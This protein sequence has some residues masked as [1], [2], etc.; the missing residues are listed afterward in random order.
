MTRLSPL[1]LSTFPRHTL[2]PTNSVVTD[3]RTEFI[4]THLLT[5]GTITAL[6]RPDEREIADYITAG[7]SHPN[8]PPSNPV[9]LAANSTPP[10]SAAGY[11]AAA[12]WGP[13]DEATTTITITAACP[14][15]SDQAP[16]LVPSG[17]SYDTNTTSTSTYS[18][19]LPP[20]PVSSIQP[21][22]S[23]PADPITLDEQGGESTW[24][25]L[26]QKTFPRWLDDSNGKPYEEAPWGD[27]TT[28]NSD[29]TVKEDVPTTNVTR[30]YEW[31]VTRTQLSPDG[32]LRDMIV[33]NNAFPGPAIEA[34]W[35]DWIEVTVHNAITGPEEGTAMHWHGMLQ[36]G[37]QWEDGTPG[38]SQCPIAPGE[39][40]TYRFQ[41]EVYGTSFWHAH[42]SAQY[43]AGVSG[44]MII[45]G[46]VQE[47]APYDV[48][49]GPVMLSDWNHIP[50]FSMVNN[51]VGTDLSKFPPAS[52]DGLI[53]GR[54]RFDCAKPSYSNNT[55]WLGT[56]LDSNMTWT[57]VDGSPRAKFRFQ[58]GKTHRL[59]LVNG[60]A[61]GKLRS[62]CASNLML[63]LTLT[64]GVQKFSI[65]G[66]TMTVI[67]TDYVPVVPYT[68][69]VITL[70][71]G[72]RTD[73]LVTASQPPMSSW[74]MRSQLPG[75]A[76]CGGLGT[77]SGP[78]GT[79]PQVLAEVYYD[80]VPPGTT[81]TSTSTITSDI[82]CENAPLTS[83][84]P[85]YAL[86]PS[87]KPFKIDLTLSLTLNETGNFNFLINDQT[88]HANFNDPMLFSA[89]EGTT[90][91]PE[92][93]EYNVYD[94]GS[95]PSI[96]LNVTNATPFV[97]PFH[98][99]G[100]TF[101]VLDVG[102]AAPPSSGPPPGVVVAGPPPTPPITVWSG[103]V[104]NPSSP[105]RRDVQII[106]AGG[107]MALQF[108]ADNPGVWPFHCHAAWHLSGGLAVNLITRASEIAGSMPEGGVEGLRAR[109][110]AKWDAW[111]AAGGVADQ[112][113]SGS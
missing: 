88:Y 50:Y 18:N 49:L 7:L 77:P 96:L 16:T 21:T 57:C 53:N 97:H 89:A 109:S 71:V 64:A 70:G 95:S 46:P 9:S 13:S 20:A 65:D 59:R 112:I 30:Y 42:Y 79:Y 37:S 63:S 41:A 11:S 24:G 106:P 19:P 23:P 2:L 80:V 101:F 56:N 60:G 26:K 87:S 54:G 35:G 82:S 100:H 33:V 81:P 108:E 58:S 74:W 10:A 113:D 8:S 107:Y 83:T 75:Q 44:P 1:S 28:K 6:A 5:T 86:A 48:D 40:Y 94:T 51:V 34:N 45:Y 91:F 110:C 38:I 102:G 84:I 104:I 69:D 111:Q 3:M 92:D 76:L 15:W 52:D 72:Q 99:H 61:D 29:A 105:M 25:T 14:T 31:T 68:A 32:V 55:D 4:I 36:R 73:I 12:G 27:R 103:S 47:E 22:W 17:W 43:T 67:A 98:L 85:D 90:S 78:G 93:P 66:H 62:V 39:S